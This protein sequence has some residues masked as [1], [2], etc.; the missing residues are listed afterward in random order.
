MVRHSL[1]P[2]M[3][4]RRWWHYI[5]HRIGR[6]PGTP[7]SIAAGFAFGAAVSFTPFMGFHILLSGLGAYFARA[8]IAA[9]IVG[10]VVGNPWTFPF[11]WWGI[12]ELGQIFTG[13]SLADIDF[14]AVTLTAL[15][16]RFWDAFLPM[17]IGGLISAVFVWP[18][19]YFPMRRA[20]DKYKK[21]AL[22][23]RIRKYRHEHHAA[24]I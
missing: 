2:P 9:A 1:W 8:S 20:I 11:I 21:A 17:S 7:Y 14:S 3:G 16:G 23:R 18:A 6:L 10:T 24:S 13:G 22:A 12:Y 15:L 5:R 4:W 19:F